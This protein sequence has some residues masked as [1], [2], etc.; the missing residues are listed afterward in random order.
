MHGDQSAAGFNANSDMI[1]SPSEGAILSTL[2]QP[3]LCR[4]EPALL[5]YVLSA[6][7]DALAT[8]KAQVAAQT[9]ANARGFF[10]LG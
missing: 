8:D 7:A 4:N 5:P 9:S 10:Q 2:M 6:V 3:T 1:L